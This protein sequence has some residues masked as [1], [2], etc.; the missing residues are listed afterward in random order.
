MSNQR[1]IKLVEVSVKPELLDT[2]KTLVSRPS[3][4][5]RSEPG[6]VAFHLSFKTDERNT[7][8]FSEVF[9]NEGA[10][11]KHKE[12]SYTQEFMAEVLGMLSGEPVITSLT[13]F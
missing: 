9:A 7:L 5:T 4:L 10:Y 8:M 2:V 3:A 12:E 6:C 11:K 1:Y 13:G